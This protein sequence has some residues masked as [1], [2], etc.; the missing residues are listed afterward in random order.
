MIVSIFS[1]TWARNDS[2]TSRFLPDTLKGIDRLA[3]LDRSKCARPPIRRSRTRL[4]VSTRRPVDVA[5]ATSEF[6]PAMRFAWLAPLALEG[7]RT[8]VNRAE[9]VDHRSAEKHLAD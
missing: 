5:S 4:R 3:S 8:D 1:S 9:G 7:R 6:E 2:P